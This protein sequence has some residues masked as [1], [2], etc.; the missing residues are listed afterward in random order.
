VELGLVSFPDQ[1]EAIAAYA[2]VVGLDDAL[3]RAGGDR[4]VDG[5]TAGTQN[6]KRHMGRELVGRGGSAASALR[7]GTAGTVEIAH[8]T[9]PCGSGR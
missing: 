4:G 2:S 6:L 5:I 9:G 3:Q 1:G 8:R 7:D